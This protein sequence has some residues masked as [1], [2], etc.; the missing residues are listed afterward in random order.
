MEYT[1]L[2]VLDDEEDG[3]EVG[4]YHLPE[5]LFVLTLC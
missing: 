3:L 2:S 1:A 4:V 5:G